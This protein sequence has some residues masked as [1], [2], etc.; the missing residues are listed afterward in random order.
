MKQLLV[1]IKD[2]A[3][4]FYQTLGTVRT[5]GEALRS[6]MDAI[7]DPNNKQLHAHPEDFDLYAVGEFDDQTGTITAY[8]EPKQLLRGLNAKS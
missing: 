3:A 4:L 1:T 7:N 6:F 8:P 5:E 2:N